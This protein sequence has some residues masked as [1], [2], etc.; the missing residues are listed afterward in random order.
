MVVVFMSRVLHATV[1]DCAVTY[2]D[3]QVHF[4]LRTTEGKEY[5][6]AMDLNVYAELVESIRGCS[7]LLSLLD[8]GS[9]WQSTD[10]TYPNI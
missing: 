7:L 5:F 3:N 2:R 1:R 4:W 6:Y 9:V 10:D 8:L